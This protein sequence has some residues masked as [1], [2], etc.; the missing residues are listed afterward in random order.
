MLKKNYFPTDFALAKLINDPN[1][2]SKSK[3]K[4]FLF[5]GYWQK[6]I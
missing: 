4:L 3:L 2:V 1:Q 5:S 6:K